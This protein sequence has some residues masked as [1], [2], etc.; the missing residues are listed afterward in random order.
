[1]NI[2]LFGE[3]VFTATV[4]QSLIDAAFNVQLIVC[5]FYENNNSH[6]SAQRIA[7]LNHIDFIRNK[8]VNSEEIKQKIITLAPDLIIS[9]HLRKVL[10]KEIFSLAKIAA[11]NVHPSLL[12][13]YRGLSPQHQ[14]LIH[15][16]KESA[17]TIHYIEEGIDT[18]DIVIQKRFEI[19]DDDYIA[20]VQ[21]KMLAIYKTLMVDAVRLLQDK[22]FKA[23]KQSQE[24][25]SYFGAVKKKDREIKLDKSRDEVYNFI[26]ALS[27]PYKGAYIN[28][29]VIWQT[30][31]VASN[32]ENDLT[33]KYLEIGL[34]EDVED[35]KL[36]IRLHDGILVSDDYEILNN[37]I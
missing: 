15:G 2:V 24:G 16:E 8:D 9:V 1:M 6:I 4:L 33:Q 11:I 27:M 26:R 18:G 19:E 7:D 5:P 28:N 10:K 20:D 29:Y 13:K 32:I 17:V 23:T 14:V 30:E 21:F 35:E 25:I 34:Y 22:N 36:Y 12:P 31:K 37:N 3:D